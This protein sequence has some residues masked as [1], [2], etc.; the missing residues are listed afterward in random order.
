[1]SKKDSSI[2]RWLPSF[3]KHFRSNPNR[4]TREF[5]VPDV[6][7]ERRSGDRNLGRG[8]RVHRRRRFGRRRCTKGLLDVSVSGA[9]GGGREGKGRPHAMQR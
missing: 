1:M 5:T 2:T 6:N 8:R 3:P 7:G 9:E 4:T